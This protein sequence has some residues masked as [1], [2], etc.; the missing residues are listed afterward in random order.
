MR[1]ATLFTLAFNLL[2]TVNIYSNTLAV[3]K[4]SKDTTKITTYGILTARDFK[5][6]NISKMPFHFYT[7]NKHDYIY[8][9]CF[10]RNAISVNLEEM[11]YSSEDIGWTDNYSDLTIT[12]IGPDGIKHEYIM[13]RPWPLPTYLA[14]FNSWLTLMKNEKYVCI[15][16]SSATPQKKKDQMVVLWYFEQLKTKKG[17][18]AYFLN[19]C[20]LANTLS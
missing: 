18:N 4:N 15:A 10:A 3:S 17:C 6:E 7:K 8:W 9:Q 16:G 14:K 12:A 5:N 1:V 20:A 19:G 2:F 11:G 13:R